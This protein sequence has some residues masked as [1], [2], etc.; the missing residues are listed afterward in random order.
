MFLFRLLGS[1]SDSELRYHLAGATHARE[2]AERDEEMSN[3]LKR[4]EDAADALR[5]KDSEL[6]AWTSSFTNIL[7]MA[8]SPP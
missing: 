4:I 5:A 6:S 3:A 1:E 2:L 8:A 7:F